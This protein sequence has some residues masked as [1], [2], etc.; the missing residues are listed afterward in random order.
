MSER[1]N[2]RLTVTYRDGISDADRKQFAATVLS[3]QVWPRFAA[4]MVGVPGGGVGDEVGALRG[5]RP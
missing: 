1:E 2:K 3:R 4:M 5:G